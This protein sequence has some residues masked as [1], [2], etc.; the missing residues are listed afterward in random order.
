MS[1]SLP[2]RQHSP[3]W[4][5]ASVLFYLTLEAER[6]VQSHSMAAATSPAQYCSD[7]SNTP[8]VLIQG[9]AWQSSKAW[10][11]HVELGLQSTICR[12]KLTPAMDLAGLPAP[13]CPGEG[14]IRIPGR[15]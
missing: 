15:L 6:T 9:V 7:K 13:R 14:V 1:C 11:G 8:I 5:P 2:S 10:K 3:Q 12:P 4:G